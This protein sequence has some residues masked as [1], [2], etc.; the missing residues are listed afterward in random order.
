ME[1]EKSNNMI[2]RIYSKPSNIGLVAG[3]NQYANQAYGAGVTYSK[4]FNRWFNKKN[5]DSLHLNMK[6]KK[7]TA[8]NNTNK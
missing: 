7:D 4:S 1:Y 5:K 3:G 6:N 2:F 8:Q